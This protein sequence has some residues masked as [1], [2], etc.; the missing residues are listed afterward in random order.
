M[1]N[2]TLKAGTYYVGDLCYVLEHRWDDVCNQIIKNH[3]C[4][5]GIFQL[6]DGT[7]F[8]SIGTMYGDGTYEDQ[9][10]HTYF[11]D[12]GLIGCIEVSA[13][14]P[15]DIETG[16]NCGKIVTFDKD[17]TVSGTRQDDDWDGEIRIGHIRIFTG[18]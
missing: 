14:Y 7:K 3:K 1:N 18:D 4:L 8:A 9:F 12:A 15:D 6:E 5:D 10:S 2:V 16:K 11:V 17:F 13:L